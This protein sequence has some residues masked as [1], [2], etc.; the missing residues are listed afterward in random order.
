M[1]GQT[2]IINAMLLSFIVVTMG[3]SVTL[4]AFNMLQNKYYNFKESIK[5]AERQLKASLLIEYVQ[6]DNASRILKMYITNNGD[7]DLVI[8]SIIVDGRLWASHLDITLYYLQSAWINVTFPSWYAL[9]IGLHKI[10]IVTQ[11]GIKFEEEVYVN[12]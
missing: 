6:F 11:D 8:D 10:I 3:V 7:T 9:T 1:K 4:L 12:G 2:N 5:L